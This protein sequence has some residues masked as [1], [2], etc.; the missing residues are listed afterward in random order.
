MN[1]QQK[2][3]LWWLAAGAG[4]LVAV[5]ALNRKLNAYDFRNKV[6]LIT[7]GARGL[8]LVMA[9][10][11]AAE[12]AR[13][14]L[15]SRD[16]QQLENARQE[17]AAEGA[18]VMVQICDVTKRQEVE[19]LIAKV[20]NTFG[21][22]DV[23]INN[24]GVIHAGPVGEMTEQDYEESI[25]THFWGPLYTVLA[26]VD[27]MKERGGGRILNVSSI[28]GKISVPHLVPYSAGKF[29]L[30]GLSEGLRAELKK[31]NITVTTATPGL[32]RSGSPRH[33]IVKGQHKKE[34]ALF[35][36]MDS[37]TL[38]SMSAEATAEKILDALRHGDAEIITTLP[39]KIGAFLH[40]FSPELMSEIFAFINGVLP[41]EGGIGKTRA[42]GYQSESP[43][44]QSPLTK[45]TQE[46]AKKNNQY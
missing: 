7:G 10:Q 15:C 12:G 3:K 41:G 45:K 34:Y 44:S 17:L 35:K 46:A 29:A 13:L 37:N 39:A 42:K 40:D 30:V 43:L 20:S 16:E 19:T 22:V 26:V 33:A 14:V 18:D 28:G 21:H 32:I 23:L 24:A 2:K 11:L 9:R 5:R 6:V 8:G 1:K 25:N 38:S 36:I 31:F 27:S 4:A